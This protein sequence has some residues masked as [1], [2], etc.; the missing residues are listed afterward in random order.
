M[1]STLNNSVA[2]DQIEIGG[3]SIHKREFNFK[4]NTDV[5]ACGSNACCRC[6]WR[7]K[8]QQKSQ[9]KFN[10]PQ[11]KWDTREN[12]YVWNETENFTI[13]ESEVICVSSGFLQLISFISFS[14]EYLHMNETEWAN[15][16][17]FA[18]MFTDN[19]FVST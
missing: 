4:W 6:R 7:W 16:D 15:E 18:Y 9:Q 11:K 12:K 1:D 3:N 17:A 2:G 10:D 5:I 13:S 19:N 8:S 14:F